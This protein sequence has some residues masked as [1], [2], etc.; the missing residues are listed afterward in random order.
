MTTVTADFLRHVRSLAA[1]GGRPTDAHLLE[2]FA[3][4]DEE[5]FAALVRRHG[6]MVLGV[7]KRVLHNHHDAE[8]AFQATFLTLARKARSIGK[9]SS[10]GSWLYQVAYHA[11][12][13]AR[14]RSARAP[15]EGL[16]D[17]SGA[18]LADPL[19]E[20]S[21]RELLAALDAELHSLPDSLS[22]PLVLLF[23]QGHT[24]DDPGR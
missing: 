18:P 21:A 22:A 8:D 20:L 14:A 6:P 24:G 23:L 3:G 7:C 17:E 4:G 1:E 19:A 13:K 12:I 15:Q 9:G 5:S 16:P 10:L 11:A 2:R